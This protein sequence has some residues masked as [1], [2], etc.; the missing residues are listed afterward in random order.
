MMGRFEEAAM[1][2]HLSEAEAAYWRKKADTLTTPVVYQFHEA[3][4]I[5]LETFLIFSGHVERQC[6]N[7]IS[8]LCMS[9]NLVFWPNPISQNK[10]SPTVS[11]LSVTVRLRGGA[12]CG[13]F[14]WG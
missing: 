10:I 12:W 3:Y 13:G 6:C 11:K 7:A 2:N 9:T 5:I 14:P 1:N 8:A 4:R